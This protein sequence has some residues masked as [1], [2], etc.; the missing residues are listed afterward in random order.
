M[1]QKYGFT[2]IELLVV[3]LIIGILAAVALPQYQTA[4][5]KTK[6]SNMIILAEA[7]KSAQER[8]YMANGSYAPS[9]Y[10]LDIEVKGEYSTEP[11]SSRPAYKV[12]DYYIFTSASQ[13]AAYWVDK[14]NKLFMM[15]NLR[16]DQ[17]NMWDGAHALCRAYTPSGKAG[18]TICKSFPTARDC[19]TNSEKGYYSCFIY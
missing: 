2:L 7:F 10:D 18:K 17:I 1:Y 12:K 5:L 15:Y 6:Y 3:V 13:A 19:G 16:F 14:E 9:I 8:Y 11:F 4:V